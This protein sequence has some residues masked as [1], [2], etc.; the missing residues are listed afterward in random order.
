MMMKIVFVVLAL[1]AVSKVQGYGCPNG[2]PM[3][4]CGDN[5]CAKPNCPAYP[6]AECVTNF[7]GNEACEAQYFVN[8]IQVTC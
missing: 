8:G 5:P 1:F 4:S 2:E 7:C 3:A 6:S